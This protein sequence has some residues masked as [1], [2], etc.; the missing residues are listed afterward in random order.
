MDWYISNCKLYEGEDHLAMV[1]GCLYVSHFGVS[2]VCCEEAGWFVLF[3]GL[4]YLAVAVILS[5][6]DLW[7]MDRR[8]KPRGK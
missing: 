7:H 4:I 8:M 1:E 6:V 2:D 5:T 3:L